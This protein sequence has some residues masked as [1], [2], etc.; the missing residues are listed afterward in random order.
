[1]KFR[2]IDETIAKLQGLIAAVPVR[3]L[4]IVKRKTRFVNRLKLA[5]MAVISSLHGGSPSEHSIPWLRA[6]VKLM[7]ASR[8]RLPITH[9]TQATQVFC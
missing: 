8:F 1:M 4:D 9:R 7:L 3:K 6:I 2:K 5:I